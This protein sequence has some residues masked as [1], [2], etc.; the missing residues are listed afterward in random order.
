VL[1]HPDTALIDQHAELDL[2]QLEE[3]FAKYARKYP[4]EALTLTEILVMTSARL[5]EKTRGFS[6]LLLLPGGAVG[7]FVEWV[8]LLW[9]AGELRDGQ[10]VLTKSEAFRFYKD[11]QFFHDVAGRLEEVRKLRAT[12]VKGNLRNFVQSWLL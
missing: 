3:M 5:R 4:G 6:E 1:R 12:S 9:L 11:P 7:T 10:H 8:A 2:A